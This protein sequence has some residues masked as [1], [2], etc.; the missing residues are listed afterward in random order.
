MKDLTNRLLWAGIAAALIF[1][2]MGCTQRDLEIPATEGAVNISFDWKNLYPDEDLPSGMRLYFYRNDGVTET[3]D[4]TSGGYTGMLPAGTYQVLA[5]NTDATGVAYRNM[6]TYAGAR[7]YA[8]SGTK[9]V[10]LSQPLHVYGTGLQGTLTITGEKEASAGITPESF[11]KKALLKII[12]TGE[13]SAV[14]SCSAMMTGVVEAVSVSTGEL[15]EE[16]GVI[17]F[18][19]S[20]GAGGFESAVTFF[21]RLPGANN[22]L[23]LVLNFTGGG[24]QTVT[25]DITDAL[26]NINTAV[27]PIE[28]NARIEVS[29]SVAGE[30]QATLKDWDYTDKNVTV[31]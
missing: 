21:G 29:G 3:R 13:S 28:V 9:A 20:S 18:V 6:D 16:T 23:T 4:C 5:H 27:I 17:A 30:S 2:D 26:K 15:L 24:S 19:L 25:V 31:N 1:P 12:L 14:A 7:V 22:E 11:V 10:Y 8:A